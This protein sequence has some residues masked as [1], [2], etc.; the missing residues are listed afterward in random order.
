[1][2]HFLFIGIVH[3][4]N[5]C[6]YVRMLS[7]FQCIVGNGIK[8]SSNLGCV[9]LASRLPAAAKLTVVLTSRCDLVTEALASLLSSFIEALSTLTAI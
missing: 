7:V 9:V 2:Y 8:K 4:I 3:I 6:M 5:K 1:M